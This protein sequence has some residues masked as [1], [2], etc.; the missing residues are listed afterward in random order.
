MKFLKWFVFILMAIVLIYIIMCALGPKNLNTSRTT[1]I[2]AA[3]SMVYNQV[4][5]LKS[6]PAWSPWNDMDTSMVITYGQ[7]SEGKGATYSWKGDPNLTGSGDMLVTESVKN[8]KT[9]V[10]M[11]FHDYGSTSFVDFNLTPKGNEVEV[12]WKMEDEKDLSFMLRGMMLALGQ[13]GKLE[14]NFDDGLA[15]LKANAEKRATGVYGGFKINPVE[16]KEK[17]YIMNRQEVDVKNIA[18]FYATNLGSLFGKVQKNGV[19]MSGK[20]CGL[21]FKWDEANGKT[22]MAAA[23]PV[24]EKLWI[25]DASSYDIPAGKGLQIDYYGDYNGTEA[26]HSAMDEYLKDHGLFNNP[27]IIEEYVTDPSEEPDPSKWLTKIT[28]YITK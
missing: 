2:K 20:P 16:E 4:N 15:A 11:N 12:E 5:N 22:D 18:Q 17:H 21:F 14:K 7:K 23:I 6:W 28:Y 19:E 27:P 9:S 25:K 26:A 13:K 3:P 10:T 24:A 1:T 8:E